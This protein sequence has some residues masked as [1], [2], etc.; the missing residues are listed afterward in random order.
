MANTWVCCLQCT[1]SNTNGQFNSSPFWW[2]AQG[3]GQSYPGSNAPSG[4]TRN[5]SVYF[6]VQPDA[7]QNLV[8][9]SDIRAS[10]GK[11]PASGGSVASPFTVS[12]GNARVCSATTAVSVLNLTTGQSNPP[13][14]NWYAVGP[15]TIVQDPVFNGTSEYEFIVTAVLSNGNQFGIDPEM[16]VDNGT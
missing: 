5:D 10:F 13:G 4:V 16:D 2:K 7:G 14:A 9:V 3:Q 11:I 15:F 8:T 6:A 1:S 12:S